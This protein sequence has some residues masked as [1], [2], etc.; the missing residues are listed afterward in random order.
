[1]E[2]GTTTGMTALLAYAT[3]IVTWVITTIGSFVDMVVAE[4]FFMIGISLMLAGAAVGFIAR[5]VRNT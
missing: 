2:G 1:M 4:P 3:E 5:L